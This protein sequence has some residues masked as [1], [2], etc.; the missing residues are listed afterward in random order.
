[1]KRLLTLF[2]FGIVLAWTTPAEGATTGCYYARV[3]VPDGGE[4]VLVY[5]CP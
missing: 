3:P 4:P 1:M 5:T 2:V